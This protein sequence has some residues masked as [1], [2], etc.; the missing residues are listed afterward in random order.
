MN[1][2][3]VSVVQFGF[4][5]KKAVGIVIQTELEKELPTIFFSNS[6]RKLPCIETAL[7]YSVVATF[8]DF[9]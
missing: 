8:I 2:I 1:C 9:L 4:Q 5:L 7:K 3:V 6:K